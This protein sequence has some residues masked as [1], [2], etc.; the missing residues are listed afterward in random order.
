MV[1][2]RLL[3]THGCGTLMVM[4]YYGER[5]QIKSEERKGTCSGVREKPGT[6]FRVAF[7]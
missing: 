3:Y 5:I 2:S 6:S 1:H 4:V 7:W